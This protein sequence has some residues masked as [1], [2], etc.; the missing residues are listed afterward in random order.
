[1]WANVFACF[2]LTMALGHAVGDV[3]VSVG[4]VSSKRVAPGLAALGGLLALVGGLPPSSDLS[5]GALL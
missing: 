4:K 5:L 2:L 1:M 3:I